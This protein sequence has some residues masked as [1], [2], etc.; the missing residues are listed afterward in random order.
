MATPLSYSAFISALKGTGLKVVEVKTN[1]KSPQ[2][3]T[4]TAKDRPWGP[5][6]GVMVHHTAT[7]PTADAVEICRKGYPG[8]PGPLTHVVVER[9]GTVYVVG[10][11]RCN[12]AGGGDPAVLDQVIAES[13]GDRPTAPTRTNEGGMDGNSRFYGIE[14]ANTGLGE[15]WPAVQLDAMKRV[16]AA[17]IKAHKGWGAK[18]VI[19]HR[20]WQRG[21]PDPQGVD[22]VK[23]RADVAKLLSAKT[24]PAPK[25]TLEQ[26]VKKLEDRV[27]ALEKTR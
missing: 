16:A 19:A 25:T 20:E 13:Y 24:A 23:F 26:R 9:T 1:G 3:H 27:T 5:V 17:I 8:L 4:R 7:S 12:H 18:S 14:A 10:Y 21:K 15:P 2:H 6:H 22:M 11:G